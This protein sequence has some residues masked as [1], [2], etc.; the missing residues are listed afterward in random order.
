MVSKCLW[1]GVMQAKDLWFYFYPLRSCCPLMRLICEKSEILQLHDVPVGS[2]CTT[3]L[4]L[5]EDC[6]LRYVTVRKSVV[7]QYTSITYILT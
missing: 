7:R 5:Q 2:V 3:P 4:I 1:P 6:M